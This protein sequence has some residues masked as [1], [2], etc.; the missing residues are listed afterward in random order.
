M[1]Y[2]LLNFH[3]ERIFEV[4]FSER[5]SHYSRLEE[6]S[7]L[8]KEESFALCSLVGSFFDFMPGHVRGRSLHQLPAW[9][10]KRADS[11]PSELTFYGGSFHPWHEGHEA[12]V[13][14]FPTPESLLVLPDNNPW[15]DEARD[16]CHWTFFK[17]LAL[18]HKDSDASFYP[19][20]LGMEEKNPTASWF[21]STQI[22]NKSLLMGDDTFHGLSR[23]Y[24]VEDLLRSLKKIYVVP[25]VMEA[26]NYEDGFDYIHKA[27]PHVEV[28][29]LP[30]H[31]FEHMSSTHIRKTQK[32]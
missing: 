10:W 16:F 7:H 12:C 20:F 17:T 23:W 2:R 9:I 28:I 8:K 24:K 6:I 22:R 11:F 13:K 4:S 25:R 21:L 14:L 29:R 18:N 19:G 15:K 27:A 30:H 1:K 3:H 26:E 32:N 31:P 5:A